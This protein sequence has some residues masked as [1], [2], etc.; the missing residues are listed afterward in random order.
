MII[1]LFIV[2][3]MTYFL[4]KEVYCTHDDEKYG[5]MELT[6]LNRSHVLGKMKLDKPIK[7]IK[8]LK[9]MDL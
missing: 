1:E 9:I 2:A 3:V 5:K 4:Y 8:H 6:P 7:P